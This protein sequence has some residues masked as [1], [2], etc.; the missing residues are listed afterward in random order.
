MTERELGMVHIVALP[1]F[2]AQ[3]EAKGLLQ[4]VDHLVRLAV[5]ECRV[6]AGRFGGNGC[7]D[8]LH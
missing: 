6:N 7:H 8:V 3:R 4:P 1:I 5:A 2:D